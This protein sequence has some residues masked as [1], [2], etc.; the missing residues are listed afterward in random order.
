MDYVVHRSP[1]PLGFASS[2]SLTDSLSHVVLDLSI[3]I[4]IQLRIEVDVFLNAEAF[5]NVVLQLCI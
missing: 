4:S 5:L 3:G 1:Y 2:A